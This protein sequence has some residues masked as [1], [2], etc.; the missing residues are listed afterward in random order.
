MNVKIQDITADPAIQS[1]VE[2]DQSAVVDYADLVR[3]GT[4][5]DPV[6]AF[7]DGKKY[8][9]ACGFHRYFAYKKAGALEI[10]CDLRKGS[11]RDAELYSIGSNAKN[12]IRMTMADRRKSVQMMLDDVEWSGW[13]DR[14]IARHTGASHTFVAYMRKPDK[15]PDAAKTQANA[16]ETQVKTQSNA[17]KTQAPAE[18]VEPETSEQDEFIAALQERNAELEKS[19]TLA[20]LPEDMKAE[21]AQLIDDLREEN[22]LLRIE[23]D[24]VKKSR[25]QFQ[26]ENA[27]LKKQVAMLN[28]KIKGQ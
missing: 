14:Q 18:P 28:K 24:A 11:R 16:G 20:T 15:K 17:G 2:I 22:R 19:L 1:R 9:L 23:I 8:W 6:I 21:A 27:Q 25:D 7:D 26:A 12:G 5:F 4:D 13:S 10:P 3:E